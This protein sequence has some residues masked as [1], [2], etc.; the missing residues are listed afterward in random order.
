MLS[1]LWSS[2]L[3]QIKIKISFH[4]CQISNIAIIWHCRVMMIITATD[5]LE[6]MDGVDD[7]LDDFEEDTVEFEGSEQKMTYVPFAN[8]K[9]NKDC[10]MVS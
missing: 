2:Y 5:S 4:S 3:F 7:M 1:C 10:G 8:L 9:A 6:A